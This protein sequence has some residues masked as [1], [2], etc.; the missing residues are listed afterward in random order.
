MA[1]TPTSGST[2]SSKRR[3]IEIEG[4]KHSNPIPSASR[5]GPLL[6]S[7]IVVGTDPATGVVPE[8]PEAQIANLFTHVGRMLDA[9]GGDWSQVARMTF[10]VD[11][12]GHR[13]LINGPWVERFPDAE[14]R[15]A[16][17]TQVSGPPPA[18]CE[19]I[20]YIED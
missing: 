17:F 8:A 1:A 6:I 13:A 18:R 4:F 3:S 10:Y 19:F 15:P 11:D 20:A 5:I 7:S 14:S 12:I 2:P 9:A 16:R